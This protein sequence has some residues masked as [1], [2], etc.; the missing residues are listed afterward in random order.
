MLYFQ[1]SKRV[2]SFC[3]IFLLLVIMISMIGCMSNQSMRNKNKNSF[4][5]FRQGEAPQDGLYL[6][7]VRI[8][9]Y[10]G[11][12][13]QNGN[14]VIEPQFLA[15]KSFSEGLAS[16]LT[17][18]GYKYIDKSGSIIFELDIEKATSF[19]EG[20]AC[21]KRKDKWGYI[22][23]YGNFVI[24]PQFATAEP[25]SEGFAVVSEN[26]IK[27]GYINKDGNYIIPPIY[28]MALPFSDGMAFVY[29]NFDVID[30]ENK[31][32]Y[33]GYDGK[34]VLKPSITGHNFDMFSEGLAIIY[35]RDNLRYGYMNKNG[36]IV[37]ES[38]F[39]SALPYSEGL[40][41]IE[42]ENICQY[43]DAKGNTKISDLDFVRI[44]NF[45]EGMAAVMIKSSW[46]FIDK[47][48]RTLIDFVFQDVG[49]FSK[50]D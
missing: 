29:P 36:D 26:G 24:E 47:Q 5:N 17:E 32:A 28:D 30:S 16:V 3:L 46:G 12:I 19:S 18:N 23:T 31:S 50:V 25:F 33:I 15:A 34:I 38:Y 7:P 2:K 10:W 21:V 43:I 49:N 41:A 40:A 4:I 8:A 11:Y 42:D 14:I 44:R 45:S 1:K 37:I 35:N 9:I 27:K 6:A 39:E 22:D 13:D 48:G 20:L